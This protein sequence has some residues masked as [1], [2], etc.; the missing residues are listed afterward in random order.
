ML[1]VEDE[2]EGPEV[3]RNGG[4][5]LRNFCNWQQL[6][7]PTSQRHPQHFDTAILFTRMVNQLLSWVEVVKYRYPPKKLDSTPQYDSFRF[8]RFVFSVERYILG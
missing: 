3:S 2:E 8:D 6:F 5:A 7:N 1:L 4:V